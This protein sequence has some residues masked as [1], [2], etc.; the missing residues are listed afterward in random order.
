MTT[1]C[2]SAAASSPG[3][4]RPEARTAGRRGIAWR[5]RRIALNDRLIGQPAL[6]EAP[7]ALC[8]RASVDDA[9]HAPAFLIEH[10]APQRGNLEAEIDIDHEDDQA[11]PVGIDL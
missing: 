8:D 3:P 11:D 10:P 7:L 9:E 5:L 2:I 6:E 4:K 1:F